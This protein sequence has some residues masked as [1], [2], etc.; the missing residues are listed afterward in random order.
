MGLY[1]GFQS[2]Q[3]Q[4]NPFVAL[5]AGM[6]YISAA[7]GVLDDNEIAEISRVVPDRQALDG[8]MQ[9]VR[10][11]PYQQFLSEA[12][13][14]L[15]PAQKMCLVLNAADMAMG[16][17]HLAAQEQQKLIQM[18]QYFQ[19]PDAHLQPCIQTL[20]IKNNLNVFR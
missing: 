7:D 1:D 12:A 10:R 20:M 6:I 18:Q 16:D 13:R 9:Y 3:V 5:V 17:G 2:N 14:L 19:I 8:A 15:S 4:L 11:V